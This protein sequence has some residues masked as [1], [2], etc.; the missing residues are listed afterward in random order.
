MATKRKMEIVPSVIAISVILM[1]SVSTIA[2]AYT[3]DDLIGMLPMYDDIDTDGIEEY[4]GTGNAT[5]W[6]TVLA[7]TADP[8]WWTYASFK[9]LL[10]ETVRDDIES[11]CASCDTLV[12]THPPGFMMAVHWNTTSNESQCVYAAEVDTG[13]NGT[14]LTEIME[15]P[16]DIAD[17]A[18]DMLE[19][20][21]RGYLS[22]R[23]IVIIAILVILIIILICI[24]VKY[25]KG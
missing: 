22:N 10:T 23:V 20:Q 14:V 18:I 3:D 16:D 13:E 6:E 25:A 2:A 7:P 1:A 11:L 19:E 17:D 5:E 8:A 24:R 9:V 15:I 12:Y 4:N 21:D